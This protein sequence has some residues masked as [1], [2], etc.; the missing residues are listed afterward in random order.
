MA[1]LL[2]GRIVS[3]ALSHVS[4]GSGSPK[5]TQKKVT[6]APERT[7]MSFGGL[8]II[9]GPRKKHIAGFNNKHGNQMQFINEAKY[10]RYAR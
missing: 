8:V 3:E 6:F 5:P 7:E 1:T 4:V 2:D 10:L 9:G